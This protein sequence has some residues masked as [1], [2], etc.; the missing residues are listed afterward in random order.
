[1]QSRR[2]RYNYGIV[3]CPDFEPSI[4]P[5]SCRRWGELTESWKAENR[6]KW[7]IAKG[8]TVLSS[9][10]IL[11]DFHNDFESLGNRRTS[12]RL[13][14]N[15]QDEAPSAFD[16]H[17]NSSTPI[18]CR[19]EVNVNVV[20]ERYFEKRV[21]SKGKKYERLA[22]VLGMRVTSGTLKFDLRVDGVVYGEVTA[23]FEG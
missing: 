22:Y 11:L 2:A 15:Q 10:P 6:L 4:H 8:Q 14:F 17:P 3:Y 13:I 12:A 9:E 21:N 23:E 16:E 1:V 20:P 5:A 7:Y 18:L 19:L